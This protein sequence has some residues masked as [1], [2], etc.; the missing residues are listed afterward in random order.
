MFTRLDGYCFILLHSVFWQSWLLLWCFTDY[1]MNGKWDQNFLFP[2]GSGTR[3]LSTSSSPMST[4]SSNYRGAGS[5][6]TTDTT[7]TY[8]T[9]AGKMVTSNWVEKNSH[10]LSRRG[11]SFPLPLLPCR[12]RL[13]SPGSVR[14]RSTHIRCDHEE[15]VRK[16]RLRR[17]KHSRLYRPG[18]FV[19][20]VPRSW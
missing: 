11:L 1:M 13:S 2:G 4:L 17:W 9:G 5:S 16:Q 19:K 6:F 7:T 3:S 12:R 20:Q 8:I 18:R 10:R 15:A 14:R